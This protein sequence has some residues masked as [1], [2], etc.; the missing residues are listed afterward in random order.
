M[1]AMLIRALVQSGSIAPAN[2]WAANR[3]PV[4]L[5]SLAEEFKG[6]QCSDASSVAAATQI[7]FLCVKAADTQTVLQQVQKDL[8]SDQI[9]VLLTNVFPFEQ[10][11]ARIP[12]RAAKLIH[13]IAQQAGA[14]V[15]LL[16]YGSRMTPEDC[17]VLENLLVPIGKLLVV[18]GAHL[19]TF[20]DVASCG[21]ALLAES[22]EEICHQASQRVPGI[23][24]DE[25]RH[26]AI[27]TLAATAGLLH[28]GT[29][30]ADLIR[31]VAVPGGMTEAGLQTLRKYLPQ[32]ISSVFEATQ[33]TEQKKREATSLD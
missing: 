5:Q 3:S 10:I 15:A 2:I 19:R 18:P 31:Q 23:S 9:C 24:V 6:L 8:R 27:D 21:P 33:S 22:I 30:P 7:L 29:D 32:L 1:G 25:L 14:G 17:T 20:A 13:S 11:E 12:C 16:S 28:S 26:A 4:R